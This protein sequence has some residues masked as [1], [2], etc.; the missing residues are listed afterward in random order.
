M[1]G[2]DTYFIVMA[3]AIFHK[4][5]ADGDANQDWLHRKYTFSFA[6]HTQSLP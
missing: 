5:A 4:Q 3:N 6:S 2:S 1:S